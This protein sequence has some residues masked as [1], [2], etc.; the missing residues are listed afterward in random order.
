[1]PLTRIIAV[2]MLATLISTLFTLPAFA[3]ANELDVTT[4]SSVPKLLPAGTFSYTVTVTN[5]SG[6]A[7]DTIDFTDTVTNGRM[8]A[9]TPPAG[10]TCDAIAG[11]VATTCHTA[12]LADTAS[13][14]V[15]FSVTAPVTIGTVTNTVSAVSDT[16]GDV[17]SGSSTLVAT[18]TVENADLQVTKTHAPVVVNP[19][20][21]F[22]Y[23]IAIKDNGPSIA[24]NVVLTDAAPTN[25]TFGTVTILSSDAVVQ[26]CPG[27]TTTLLSC[28]L[29]QP[30]AP[31]TTVTFTVPATLASSSTGPVSNTASV[32]S[33]T[34]DSVSAN[35]TST[36]VVAAPLADVGVAIAVDP[37]T[38]VPGGTVTYT[39]T[40][41][42]LST[43]TDATNVVVTD[44]L[45]A[46][47]TAPAGST[48][49]TIGTAAFASNTWTW[50]IPTLVKPTA[51]ATSTVV[52]A[53]FD[54]VVDPTTTLTTITNTVSVLGTETDPVTTN[55]TASVDLTIVALVSD[56]DITTAVDN[57]KP[58]QGDTIAI[59]IQV[60]NHGPD[61]ATN[62][63]FK[64]VLPT[65]LKYKSCTGCSGRSSR[66]S[67]TGTFTTASIPTDFAVTVILHVTVQAS[68]GVLKN[69]ASVVSSDQSDPDG[70]NDKDA[71][72]ISIGGTNGS[73]SGSGG[74]TTSGTSGGSTTAFTGSTV[75]QLTPWF[76]LL[77]TL[78]LIALEWARRMRP[79]S[80]I[81]ST[82]GFDVPF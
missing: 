50:T 6:V 42:N 15:T 80:P 37:T 51:P 32:S 25:I 7:A 67:W 3:A 29:S 77:F 60:S 71:L 45:P 41:T 58:D 47:L 16:Q 73:G 40:V 36:D 65:G 27:M 78:G 24:S 38:A 4:S 18:T 79:V 49:T 26:T 31:G 43:T 8:T 74:G 70:T 39:V 52:S 57:S 48:T 68:D 82:Y 53:S 19:G 10:T 56:L 35:N 11:N 72:N 34:L 54:A 59:G 62:V 44:A 64:D 33:A 23:T 81:G 14:T 22:T 2:S 17:V 75:D 55:N 30:I 20:D 12:A 76:M 21:S 61:D 69:V 63:V 1:M 13:V 66:R 9:A 46:G 5:N 28:T